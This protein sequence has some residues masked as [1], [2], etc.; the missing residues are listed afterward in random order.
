MSAKAKKLSTVDVMVP[1]SDQ[2]LISEVVSLP[3]LYQS[4]EIKTADDCQFASDVLSKAKDRIKTL[5]SNRKKITAPLDQAKKAAM[6]FFRPATDAMTK[7]EGVLKPKIAA[8][9]NEQERLRREA[10][11][12]AEEKARKERERL[13]ARAEKARESGKDE[14]AAA[15]EL[16]AATTV[17]VTPA[18]PETKISGA[19]VRK[20]WKGKVTDVK[21]L[22]AAVADGTLPPTVVEFKQ[23]ELNKFA[24]VFQN[25]RDIPGLEIFQESVVASR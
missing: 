2:E 3:D 7:L 23:A 21:A 6:D 1:A 20:V 4:F 5:E 13:E 10:E 14:K 22:C 16:Q 12:A 24:G 17:A 11:A 8:Y 9:I 18:V 15:L 25:T 19:S